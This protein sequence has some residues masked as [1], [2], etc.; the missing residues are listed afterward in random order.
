MQATTL[1]SRTV[2]LSGALF[3]LFAPRAPAAAQR[4]T[5]D[6]PVDRLPVSVSLPLVIGWAE[7]APHPGFGF[8][9]VTVSAHV[10]PTANAGIS[11]RH[12]YGYV[13]RE[14]CGLTRSECAIGQQTTS[15]ALLAHGEVYPLHEGLFFVRVAAGISWIREQHAADSVIH[16]SRSWPLTVLTATGWDIRVRGHFFA[17]PL[18]EVLFTSRAEPALRT[19]PRWIT[20]AGVAVTIR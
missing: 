16:E 6:G 15:L 1:T 2:V 18:V 20:F 3:Q 4:A 12:W 5:A 9:G 10:S 11:V 8:S 7:S 13:S 14:P 17:T 19:S